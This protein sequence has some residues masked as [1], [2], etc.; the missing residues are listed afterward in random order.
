VG[1]LTQQLGAA[2]VS[3]GTPSLAVRQKHAEEEVETLKAAGNAAVS[4]GEH[5]NAVRSYTEASDRSTVAH[6]SP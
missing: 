6:C 5:E 3:P 1:G 4:N 2:A